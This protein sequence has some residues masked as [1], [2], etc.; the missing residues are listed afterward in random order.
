MPWPCARVPYAFLYTQEQRDAECPGLVPIV[1]KG[2]CAASGVKERGCSKLA[3]SGPRSL[4]AFQGFLG[5][6]RAKRGVNL[7]DQVMIAGPLCPHHSP[8][9]TP[10]RL[11]SFAVNRLSKGDS[12]VRPGKCHTNRLSEQWPLWQGVSRCFPGDSKREPSLPQGQGIH[13]T[14]A[15]RGVEQSVS[16]PCHKGRA[17]TTARRPLTLPA[18]RATGRQP[19]RARG[20]DAVRFIGPS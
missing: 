18:R 10:P 9:H 3:S 11:P 13:G 20:A 15:A 17:S 2:G 14:S 1:P 8:T 16:L 4:R 12:L 6:R 5:H 7:L 19:R